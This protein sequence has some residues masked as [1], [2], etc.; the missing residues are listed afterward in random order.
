[1]KKI[2]RQASTEILRIYDDPSKFGVQYKE[3]ESPLT[4]AD[5]ASNEV[6]CMS[7]QKLESFPIISEESKRLSYAERAA[8]DYCWLVDPLDGTKEFIKRNGEFTINVALVLK[9]VV[10]LGILHIPVTGETFYA[11][12]GHG[13]YYERAGKSKRLYCR[14]FDNQASGLTMVC[15]RSH[16]NNATQQ[17]M[18]RYQNPKLLP[19]G[20]ALKFTVIVNGEADIYPR[21]GPTME[22]ILLRLRFCWKKQVA[23]FLTLPKEH[24]YAIINRIYSILISLPSVKAVSCNLRDIQFRQPKQASSSVTKVYSFG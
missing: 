8:Y 4:A 2:V 1:M 19:K 14:T 7:L 24:L 12:Q 6:I 10:V 23:S 9:G 15:S 11:A 3:D 16:L 5:K 13:A 20:S 18:Q 22:W 17:Y 21:I